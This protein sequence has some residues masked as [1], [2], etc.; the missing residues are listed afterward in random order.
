MA[1]LTRLLRLTLVTLLAGFALARPGTAAASDPPPPEYQIKAVFL[2]N[3]ARFV[4]WPPE[5]FPDAAAPLRIAVLGDDPFGA[6]LDDAVRGE[7]VNNRSVVV[8]RFRRIEELGS[9]HVLFISRSETPRLDEVLSA[10]R[11][12]DILTVSDADR[13]ALNGGM[14]GF[15]KRDAKVRLQINIEAAKAAKL[16]ISSKLLRP[17]EIIGGGRPHPLLRSRPLLPGGRDVQ[18]S[19]LLFAALDPVRRAPHFAPVPF[20]AAR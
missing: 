3:F 13:F 20:R 17:A 19:P 12:R 18:G 10:L 14:I 6:F 1:L 5:A 8:Q 15:V 11:G 4:D 9:C 2:L 7:T 16:A